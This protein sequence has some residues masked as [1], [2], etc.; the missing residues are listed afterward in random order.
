MA[1]SLVG[2]LTGEAKKSTPCLQ[3]EAKD[4]NSFWFNPA[5]FTEKIYKV[6]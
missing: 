5:P 4:I 2:I 1:I 3:Q 6:M